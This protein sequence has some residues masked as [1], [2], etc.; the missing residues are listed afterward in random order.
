MEHKVLTLGRQHESLLCNVLWAFP[1]IGK[2]QPAAADRSECHHRAR[3]EGVSERLGVTDSNS[4]AS[5]LRRGK[6]IN[7]KWLVCNRGC[8]ANRQRARAGG[9]E[10]CWVREERG[11]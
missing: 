2:K 5:Q 1:E 8:K 4:D 7:Q 10:G 6:K 9:R 11:A 3:R